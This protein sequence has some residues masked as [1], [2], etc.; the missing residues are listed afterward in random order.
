MNKTIEIE[1]IGGVAEV[2]EILGCAK[3][4][5]VALRRTAAFPQPVALLAST[6]LWDLTEVQTFKDSW[7]RHGK[8]PANNEPTAV[9]VAP[10]APHETYE[11]LSLFDVNDYN[12]DVALR[13]A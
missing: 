4:Q 3:Q 7:K 11:Q 9:T 1:N 6:P 10:T 12:N 5:I 2:A 13:S 8:R